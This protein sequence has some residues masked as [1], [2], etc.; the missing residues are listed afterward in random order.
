VSGA[1]Y[2]FISSYGTD[3]HAQRRVLRY[4][5]FMKVSQQMEW[6]FMSLRLNF[7][8]A[9]SLKRGW[10]IYKPAVLRKKDLLSSEP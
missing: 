4:L 1:T 2:G 7:F 6:V 3:M 10:E 8:E 9:L 5:H